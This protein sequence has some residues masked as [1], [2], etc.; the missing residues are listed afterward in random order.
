MTKVVP[1]TSFMD[2]YTL[3]GDQRFIADGS[4]A[5]PPHPS[6]DLWLV[7]YKAV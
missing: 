6:L 5:V 1:A 7:V 2:K 3:R 4:P